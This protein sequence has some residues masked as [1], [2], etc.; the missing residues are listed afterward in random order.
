MLKKREGEKNKMDGRLQNQK[1]WTRKE[2]PSGDS[3]AST[4]YYAAA[5]TNLYKGKTKTLWK[6]NRAAEWEVD[7]GGIIQ[8]KEFHPNWKPATVSTGYTGARFRVFRRG[9][10]RMRNG[11]YSEE[12]IIISVAI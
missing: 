9:L 10:R 3:S 1:R 5:K 7:L 2:G 6:V 12:H 4:R 8:G 11:N